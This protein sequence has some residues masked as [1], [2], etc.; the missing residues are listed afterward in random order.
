M[1]R[2]NNKKIL[3]VGGAGYIGS[4]L[5]SELLK[6]NYFVR[7]LDRCFFGME[8]IEE[9]QNNPNFEYIKDDIRNI[10]KEA[11]K[12]ID[13]VIHLAAISNDPACELKSSATI[14]INYRGTVHLAEL[15]KEAGA[16]RFIFSSSCSVYGA[17]KNLQLT[18]E[19]PLEPVSLYAKTKIESEKDLLSLADDNF[20]VTILRNG[21]VY[22]L[23]RRMRFDLIVNVMTLHAFKN[24]K[25]QIVGG[26]L[27]WRPNI[28]IQDV[29]KAFIMTLETPAEKIQKQI[30]NVGTNEQNYQTIQVANMVKTI[31]PDTIIEPVLSDQEKRNYNVNFDKIKDVLGFSTSKTVSDGIN[32]IKEA[33]EKGMISDTIKTRTVDYYRYLLENKNLTI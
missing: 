19:S 32:E 17:G 23:S 21:T 6:L 24:K 3:V 25:I 9:H 31:I 2:N 18:E 15:A 16:K 8:P 22:G 33:L 10:G 26:G 12:D 29:S 7:V 13:A 5:V 11:V 4:V 1:E 27:Q 30:F 20:I 28:H 14:D